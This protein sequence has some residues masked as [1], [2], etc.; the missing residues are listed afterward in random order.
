MTTPTALIR[1]KM[2][3]VSFDM[4]H[5]PIRLSLSTPTRNKLSTWVEDKILLTDFQVNVS[6]QHD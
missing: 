2:R 5:W 3:D 1:L 6:G 4:E